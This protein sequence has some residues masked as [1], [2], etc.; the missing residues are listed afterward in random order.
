MNEKMRYPTFTVPTFRCCSILLT[1]E[2]IE[3]ILDK[4]PHI[5][6]VGL[7]ELDKVQHLVDLKTNWLFS[8]QDWPVM[9]SGFNP[10]FSHTDDTLLFDPKNLTMQ[11]SDSS[12]ARTSMSYPAM[13]DLA[14]KMDT[15]KID[16]LSLPCEERNK[17]ASKKKIERCNLCVK[18]AVEAI[19]NSN[20]RCK[21]VVPLIGGQ[22]HGTGESASVIGITGS[23]RDHDEVVVE[24]DDKILRFLRI[25]NEENSQGML[26]KII[27][28][29]KS[30]NFQVFE[31]DLP[32][33]FAKMGLLLDQSFAIVDMKQTSMFDTNIP[34]RSDLDDVAVTPNCVREA[35]RY[36]RSYVHHL[37]R[38]EELAGPIL[39]ATINLFHFK[40]LFDSF[41]SSQTSS[42]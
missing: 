21:F 10:A 24:D 18:Q 7:G 3:D 31:T 29:L 34:L 41:R 8:P 6:Q 16:V 35:A 23:R 19:R 4:E 17:A 40:A 39:L 38:C 2:E 25:S 30:G 36:M 37:F 20:C 9:A 12:G 27:D 28:G 13:V 14:M 26:D 22:V 33:L 1:F 11:F 15:P 5:V 42:D 32:F